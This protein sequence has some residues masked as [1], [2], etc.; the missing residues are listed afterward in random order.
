MFFTLLASP[1]VNPTAEA[2]SPIGTPPGAPELGQGTMGFCL[3]DEDQQLYV[4][5]VKHVLK[6]SSQAIIRVANNRYIWANVLQLF[7]QTPL[8]RSIL[9]EISI[10][11]VPPEFKSSVTSVV[12]NIAP[13]FFAED[14]PSNPRDYL[15][16]VREGDLRRQLPLKVHMRGAGSG[17]TQ[18]QMVR[19]MKAHE[20][21]EFVG[22]VPQGQA[23]QK[24]AHAWV[25]II[26]Q[27]FARAGDSGGPVWAKQ[28]GICIPLSLMVGGAGHSNY[29]FILCIEVFV[30]A[31]M[32]T[33][34]RLYVP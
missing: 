2:G 17:R 4:T 6:T 18:G 7:R 21:D 16:L 23:V 34:S 30:E 5:T 20:F 12:P 32:E 26:K 14:Q 11:S 1:I 29:A 9:D 15:A 28:D 8:C 22:Y 3:V 24:S 33:T 27:P 13:H 10:A 25:G 19:I 31:A